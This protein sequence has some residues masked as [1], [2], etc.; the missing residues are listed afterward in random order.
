M[1]QSEVYCLFVLFKHQKRQLVS[2][3]WDIGIAEKEKLKITDKIKN[4]GKTTWGHPS[5]FLEAQVSKFEI[6]DK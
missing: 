1:R 6:L 2:I 4:K 3:Y 5:L